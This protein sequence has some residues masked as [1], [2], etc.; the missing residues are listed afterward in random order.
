[1]ATSFI[2]I[3]LHKIG[4]LLIKTAGTY[5]VSGF[6]V[7]QVSSIVVDNVSTQAILGL[8]P[9]FFMQYLF[10]VIIIGFQLILISTYIYKRNTL[11]DSSLEYFDELNKNLSNKKP[12]I[13]IMP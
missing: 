6:A 11:N 12:K 7:I 3:K 8:K 10:I 2:K 1:M 9:E 5:V 4:N 13:G